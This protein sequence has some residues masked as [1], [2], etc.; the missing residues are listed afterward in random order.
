MDT[1]VENYSRFKHYGLWESK[2]NEL[3]NYE[4]DGLLSKIISN[5]IIGTTSKPLQIVLNYYEWSLI[6]L[7]KYIDK[8][9][10]FKN[11]HYSNR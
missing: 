2:K 7:L 8:L 10:H 6:F 1:R 4:R 3:Y 9:K 5:K 11:P